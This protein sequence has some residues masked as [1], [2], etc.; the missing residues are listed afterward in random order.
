[1]TYYLNKI[2]KESQWDVPTSPATAEGNAEK[3][4]QCSHLLVKHAGSRR[5]GKTYLISL[6][7]R[8]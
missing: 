4:I 3:K 6:I 7:L 2:T 5:P 8:I 1:M